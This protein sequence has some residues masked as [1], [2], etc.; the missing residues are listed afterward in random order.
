M[1][2][3]ARVTANSTRRDFLKSAATVSAVALTIGFEWS[4]SSRRAFAAAASPAP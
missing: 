1:S 3:N 4:G 2:S